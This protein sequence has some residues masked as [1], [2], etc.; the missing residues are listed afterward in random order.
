MTLL[1][2]TEATWE[3][4]ISISS[5]ICDYRELF[6]EPPVCSTIS[7]EICRVVEYYKLWN[8]PRCRILLTGNFSKIIRY[9]TVVW[10]GVVNHPKKPINDHARFAN[11]ANKAH[12]YKHKRGLLLCFLVLR[13][14]IASIAS[15]FSAFVNGWYNRSDEHTI[16]YVR[17]ENKGINA[18]KML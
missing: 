11:R 14:I 2:Q 15:D 12:P 1:Q 5:K 17:M 4:T 9:R 10:Q 18:M 3:S 6:S 7:Y 16:Q 8:L 13:L